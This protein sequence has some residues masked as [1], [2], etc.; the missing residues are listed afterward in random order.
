MR[1]W[2]VWLLCLVSLPAWAV[3]P[4]AATPEEQAMCG[5]RVYGRLGASPDNDKHMH[6]YCDGLRF[7]DRALRTF[8]NPNDKKHYLNEAINNLDYVLSHT[9]KNYAMRAEVHMAKA[10][11]Y[12]LAGE[13][14]K[15]AAEVVQI[16]QYNVHWPELYHALAD[17]HQEAGNK[18]K[19]LETITEG[20]RHNPESKGLQRRYKELGGKEP[21]PEPYAQPEETPAVEAKPAA[22]PEA[23]EVTKAAE[24]TSNE[25][26][27]IRSE[28]AVPKSEFTLVPDSE[29]KHNPWCRL[30]PDE[31]RSPN[32]GASMPP[33]SPTTPP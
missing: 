3:L 9:A 14:A 11:A 8:N 18:R 1:M 12:R 13:K 24:P 17:S 21:Y 28:S 5:A 15:A 4:Y 16:T 7:I 32:P 27:H 10:R 29:R 20:L 30:C 19:A 23:D 33:A 26:P 31:V 6:H 2:S 22:E 25:A